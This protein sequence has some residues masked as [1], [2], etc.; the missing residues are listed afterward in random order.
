MGITYL[1]HNKLNSVCH[2]FSRQILWFHVGPSN[3][4][5]FIIAGYYLDCVKKLE[6][7]IKFW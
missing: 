4:D 2:R 6:G 3:N 1:F 5:P 7:I